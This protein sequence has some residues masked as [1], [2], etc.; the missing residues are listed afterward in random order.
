MFERRIE[1]GDPRSVAYAVVVNA[2]LAGRPDRT[3]KYR[4]ASAQRHVQFWSSPLWADAPNSVLLSE[5]FVL[6]LARYFQQRFVSA[7]EILRRVASRTP[8]ALKRAIRYSLAFVRRG[9]G[10]WE[11]IEQL[12][13]RQTPEFAS[14]FEICDRIN[15]GLDEHVWRATEYE[16]IVTAMHPVEVLAYASLF[17]FEHMLPP[18]AK[19][20]SRDTH[21]QFEAGAEAISQLLAATV[22]RCEEANL[23]LSELDIAKVIRRTLSPF[24]FPTDDELPNE[25]S[26]GA[27]KDA[28]WHRAAANAFDA[29][30]VKAFA[31]DDDRFYSVVDDALHADAAEGSSRS[32]QANGRKLELL[33][34]YWF[35]RA[36]EELLSEP[37]CL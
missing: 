31:F 35:S 24:L 36:I 17:A 5:P 25:E 14:F 4:L 12:E 10:P 22:R 19:G 3:G 1:L 33:H 23:Q 20:V 16:A 27:L 26:Y 37:P 11:E 30:W 18:L 2:Y 15:S 8:E 34:H 9:S 21:I 6:A 28:L 13:L 32:W 7:T 29:H